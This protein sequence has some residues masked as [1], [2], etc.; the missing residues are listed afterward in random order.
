M[1]GLT[2]K[3]IGDKIGLTNTYG[4]EPILSKNIMREHGHDNT[5]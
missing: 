5:G 4:Y 1:T 3:H 2:L